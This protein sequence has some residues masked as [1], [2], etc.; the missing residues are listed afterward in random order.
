MVNNM[1]CYNKTLL[2]F[3]LTS[4]L[5]HAVSAG[6]TTTV[7]TYPRP[8]GI[9]GSNRYSV[10]VRSG[11]Q[12]WQDTP[13][14]RSVDSLNTNREAAWTTFSFDGCIDVEITGLQEPV[15]H[16]AIRPQVYQ[17]IP[18]LDKG[19]IRLRL[20]QPR[21]LCLEI[22]YT[23][24]YP[25]F[26]FAD[27]LEKNLPAVNDP[28]TVFFGPGLH[29]IGDRYPV[30]SN[31]TYCLAGGAYIK[32][33]FYGK[34]AV[35]NVT[36]R[37]RGIVDSGYQQWIHPSQGIVSSICFEDGR[38]ITLEGITLLD[39]GNFLIKC[40]MKRPNTTSTFENLK[41]FGWNKNSDG[42]HVSD[43]DWQDHALIGNARGT[44]IVVKDCLILA[45][46]DGV[47]MCDGVTKATVAN[48]VFWDNGYG[49]TFCLSWAGSQDVESALI[50]N[51]HVI[52][53][54]G[55]NP[56]FRARHAG[57]AEIKN[58]LFEDITVEGD[59]ET[60]VGLRIMDHR[61]D[62]D[63]GHGSIHDITFRNIT[64][65]GRVQRNWIEGYDGNSTIENVTFENL[66]I[67]NKPIT[68]SDCMPLQTNEFTRNI[69]FTTN[70]TCKA[71]QKQGP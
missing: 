70:D 71:P 5:Q 21:K 10:K 29:D 20:N 60:L 58:V 16:V 57:D 68:N 22:N 45:N 14:Y 63:P 67:D 35:E 65:T 17:I 52:H 43:M 26:L 12:R 6:T 13:V 36:I 30:K 33:S 66:T 48:S 7:Q 32:G 40:Q 56:V 1:S 9:E 15:S 24:N 8:A 19:K 61:Y 69:R 53:K 23:K 28:Q 49:A 34:G 41:L 38:N 39:A 2:A 46:D 64:V 62:Q 55:R 4:I 37:G 51:C 44:R 59:V 11:T 27:P 42:I 54:E 25:L 50:R 31:T 18:A 3:L 47:L